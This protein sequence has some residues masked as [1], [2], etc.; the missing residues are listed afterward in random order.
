MKKNSSVTFLKIFSFCLF[1]TFFV[2]CKEEATIDDI[3]LGTSSEVE[4]EDVSEDSGD[5]VLG[6]EESVQP[7][8]QFGVFGMLGWAANKATA[9]KQKVKQVKERVK[10]K[11][12]SELLA[13]EAE[14]ALEKKTWER[15]AEAEASALQASRIVKLT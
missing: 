2:S 15:I 3:N 6:E 11:V 12:K 4:E 5:E 7:T 1:I 9:A 10:Q 14:I 8:R 13:A